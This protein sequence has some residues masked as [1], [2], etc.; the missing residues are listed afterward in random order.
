MLKRRKCTYSHMAGFL[1]LVCSRNTV[2]AWLNN[3]V[4]RQW[5]SLT[6]RLNLLHTFAKLIRLV[7]AVSSHVI[8]TESQWPRQTGR[9]I[10]I[11]RHWTTWT[12]CFVHVLSMMITNCVLL[13]LVWSYRGLLVSKDKIS[14]SYKL[15]N[16]KYLHI[17]TN[18]V[19]VI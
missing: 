4:Q 10:E 15:H 9:A 14:I 7:E 8:Q 16:Y 2:V 17:I 18:F 3:I 12:G 5:I 6:C 19:S 11:G 13:S 1:A